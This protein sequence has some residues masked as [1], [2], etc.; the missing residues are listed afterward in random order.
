AGTG[1][2]AASRIDATEI[3]GDARDIEEWPDAIEAKLQAVRAERHLGLG[4][5]PQYCGARRR[6]DRNP[7]LLDRRHQPPGRRNRN[8]QRLDTERPA[9]SWRVGKLRSGQR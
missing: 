6:N 2:P 9:V 5:V 3:H 8:E 1:G 7:L 4:L